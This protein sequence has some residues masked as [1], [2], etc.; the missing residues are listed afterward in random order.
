MSRFTNHGYSPLGVQ[1][2]NPYQRRDPRIPVVPMDADAF[3]RGLGW[4]PLVAL[5]GTSLIFAGQC[6]R[7]AL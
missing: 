4:F 7:W 6:I 2:S 1:H 3:K 5:W